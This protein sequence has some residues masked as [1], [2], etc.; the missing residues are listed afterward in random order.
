M[1]DNSSKFRL[2]FSPDPLSVAVP[3]KVFVGTGEAGLLAVRK[4]IAGGYQPLRSMDEVGQSEIISDVLCDRGLIAFIERAPELTEGSVD[5]LVAEGE[6]GGE[7][8]ESCSGMRSP[9]E[10]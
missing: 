5:H 6:F 2:R 3:V 4:L 7:P 1:T 9:G 8:K 10:Q